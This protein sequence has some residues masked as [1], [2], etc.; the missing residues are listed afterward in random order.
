[1]KMKLKKLQHEKVAAVTD[2]DTR[3]TV[4]NKLNKRRCCSHSRFD[5]T[6]VK[7]RKYLAEAKMKIAESQQPYNQKINQGKPITFSWVKPSQ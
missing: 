1:M 5:S 4:A 2:A 6:P 3:K 7:P